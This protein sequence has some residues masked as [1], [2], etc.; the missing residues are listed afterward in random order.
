MI[1]SAIRGE[2]GPASDDD[3]VIVLRKPI[4]SWFVDVTEIDGRTADLVFV[5]EEELQAV[6]KR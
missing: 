5:R 1:G 4:G 2:R 6:E 3:L